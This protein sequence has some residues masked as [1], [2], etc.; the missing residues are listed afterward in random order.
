[1]QIMMRPHVSSNLAL[2]LAMAAFNLV[3]PAEETPVEAKAYPLWDGKEPV[4]EYARRAGLEPEMTLDLGD[5]VK[6]E[7]VL[8]PAGR[9]TMGSPEDEEGRDDEEG[10]QHDVTIGQ[11]FYLGKLEVTQK[12]YTKIVKENP[13]DFIGAKN[14]VDNASW[15]DAR[16]FCENLGRKTGRTIRLPSEAEWEYAC[17]AGSKTPFHPPRERQEAQPLTDEQRRR[18]TKLF[19]VGCCPGHAVESAASAP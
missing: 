10:P 14:P 12:Q 17:R 2:V 15:N 16:T 3:G 1:M 11:P 7:F 18:V 4:A 8:I 5:G 6:M 13:S 19:P 9:F